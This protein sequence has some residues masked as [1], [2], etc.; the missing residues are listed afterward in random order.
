M[1]TKLYQCQNVSLNSEKKP[2]NSL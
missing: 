1:L 2:F